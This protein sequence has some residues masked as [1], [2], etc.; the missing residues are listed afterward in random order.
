MAAIDYYYTHASPWA[1][2]GHDAFLEVAQ[3]HRAEVRF[4]PV[5]LGKVFAAT[6]GL[7][8]AKRAPA[9]RAYRLIELARWRE[10]VGRPL[11]LEPKHFPFDPSLADRAAI[12]IVVAGGSPAA[13]SGAAMA[14]CWCEEHD[15]AE[16]TV[17]ADLLAAAGHDAEA[18]LASA[19]SDEVRAVYEKNA[20]D[21]CA[22]PIIGS[23]CYVLN[24]EPFWGQDRIPL[25]DMALQSGRPP[26]LAPPIAD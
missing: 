11:V 18:V 8:L 20:V 5:P 17:I 19:D 16:R 14:A 22:V 6:G 4:R 2:L 21:G 1:Y 7:P 25:L 26:F 24:G 23:P 10:V 13:F 15:L 12:A 3:R 9:R